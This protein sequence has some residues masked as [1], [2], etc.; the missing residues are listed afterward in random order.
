MSSV[1]G[2]GGKGGLDLD[3]LWIFGGSSRMGR[4]V[5]VR[6]GTLVKSVWV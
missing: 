6:N 1:S 4:E 5:C 2:P 3:H